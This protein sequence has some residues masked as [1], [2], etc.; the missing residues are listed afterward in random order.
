MPLMPSLW[1]AN[2]GLL[3]RHSSIGQFGDGHTRVLRCS[4]SFDA[5]LDELLGSPWEKT[6][7]KTKDALDSLKRLLERSAPGS[8]T[9]IFSGR[10]SLHR[11]LHL[12]DYVLDKTYVCCIVLSSKWLR[13]NR[14]PNGIYEWPPSL[15]AS[16]LP[17][18]HH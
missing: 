18:L 10:N 2:L 14:F 6:E 15:P 12:N 4:A 1:E 8:S 5:F 13:S 11:M 16:L 3:I 9:I 17:V 7:E